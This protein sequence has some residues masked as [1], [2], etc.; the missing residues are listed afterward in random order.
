MDQD[1]I[2]KL[3]ID[4]REAGLFRVNRKSFTDAK[5]LEMEKREVFDRCWLYAGHESEIPKAGD[6]VTRKVGGR[7]LILV[8]SPEGKPQALLNTCSHRGNEV[9]REKSGSARTFTCFYHAW[10][11]DTCGKLVGVPG[12][13]AYPPAFDRS[14]MGLKPAPR[15][16]SYRGLM[17]VSYDPGI[18]DL[19][20]YLGPAAREYI[21]YMLDFGQG[22]VKIV[23]GAQAYSMKAN[24]KLLVENSIDGYHLMS[25][26][27]RYVRKFLPD[28]GMDSSKWVGPNRIS[29]RAYSL[30]NGH[31][32]IETPD[33]GTPLNMSAGPEL[34]AIR[35]NLVERFG[36]EHAA[37]IADFNRNLF[38]FP[39][40]ILISLWRTI[41]TFY[42][43]SP[44]HIEI[45]AWALMPDSDSQELRQKRFENFISFLGPAGFGTPDDV[46]GL[47]GCQRGFATQQEVPWSDI[48]RGMTKEQPT[49][50]EEL[51]MRVFWR[52]WHALM[53]GNT[54]PVE[55]DDRV[56][57]HRPV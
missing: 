56:R 40:L 53:Q 9:C 29:G 55:C 48:S 2:K 14:E 37:R 7:P 13:D 22:D 46:S 41:R 21:D 6:F 28:I 49:N 38:I 1:D 8:R 10:S 34:A 23:Q 44:D 11:F 33:R 54:G 50:V 47:E 3:I 57:E 4:N 51:Q 17:F 15:F 39:N 43:V 26:H 19:A 32:V 18:V 16:E 5:I 30:G 35:A 25:T 42:P 45:D 24:W 52:R 31:A 20:T 12:E 36:E 27:Q